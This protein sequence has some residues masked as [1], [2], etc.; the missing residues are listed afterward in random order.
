MNQDDVDKARRDQK[1]LD[2]HL[3]GATYAQ[4]ARQLDVAPATAK[5]A[6]HAALK[7]RAGD[8]DVST[9]AQVEIAR[10]DSLLLAVWGEA[11]SGNLHA[12][13]RAV[14]LLE[15]RRKLAHPGVDA[16]ALREA[17]NRSASTSKQLV[18][19]LD[20]AI[21][22]AGRT[23]VSHI[24]KVLAT[25]TDYEK[26]KA[27][28]LLPHVMNT[29]REMLATPA[30]RKALGVAAEEADNEGA[31]TLTLLRGQAQQARKRPARR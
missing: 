23:T 21:I 2:L 24:D 26:T 5:R 30:S 11:R 28:Y 31:A 25:G 18:D 15:E 3:A 19:G 10:I 6:V 17:F 8:A 4:I 16:H 1:A 14:K 12:V 9:D 13:D 22:E 7:A 29:L 20:D 27:L